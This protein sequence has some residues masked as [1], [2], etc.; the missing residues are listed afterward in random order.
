MVK[1]AGLSSFFLPL[2]VKVPVL[3]WYTWGL[4]WLTPAWPVETGRLRLRNRGELRV[5]LC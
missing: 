3:W 2:Q 4:H 1:I 5:F